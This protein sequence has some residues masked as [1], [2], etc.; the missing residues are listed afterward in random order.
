MAKS[1][2][3]VDNSVEIGSMER[4]IDFK[5]RKFKFSSKQKELLEICLNPD[6]KAVF[7]AGPA[8][9]SKA[10]PLSEPI[11]TPNGWVNMGDIKKGDLV[12]TPHGTPTEVEGVFPQGNKE[13]FKIEFN[14]GSFTHCCDDH[15][16]LTQTNAERYNRKK[17]KGGRI[18]NEK[19]GQV[20]SLKEIRESLYVSG[21]TRLNHYI[22]ITQPVQFEP[23]Q[24]LIHPYLL[25][26]LI[27]DGG[28]T[29]GTR[30]TTADKEIVESFEKLL[31]NN[32]SIHPYKDQY[33]FSIVGENQKNLCWDEIKEMGLNTKSHLKFIPENYLIDSIENRIS[34][35]QG[36]MDTDGHTDSKQG[37]AIYTT[38]SQRLAFDVKELIES[39]GGVA[40]ITSFSP[41]FTHLGEKKIGKIA[42]R[43]NV[44]LPAHIIPFSLKRKVEKYKPLTK[45]FPA[46][47]VRSIELIGEEECQCIMVKDDSHLY[48]TKDYIVTHNTYMA[49]YA[50][51]NLLA[52]NKDLEMTYIRS[53]AESAD[54]GIGSLPG[55]VNEKFLPFSIPLDDKLDEIITATSS[56]NMKKDQVIGIMPINFVRG[57]SWTSRVVVADES[58][59]FSHKELV[60][61][62]TR[63]G[64]NAKLFVCGDLMQSDIR[65]SG[66]EEMI[67]LFD[68]EDS[69]SKGI[70]VF[71]FGNEDIYRSEILRFIVAKLESLPKRRCK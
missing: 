45:Y 50:A 55:D 60:T 68:D 34:L 24:H 26:A 31:P 13:V 22:P 40:R 12:M 62:I 39:L 37:R 17:V 47:A 70:H 16:W 38:T 46:R 15:L 56:I 1:K 63:I 23:K 9:S 7:I 5:Q 59:N 18:K 2:K 30:F 43:V 32:H 51:I 6:T 69:K 53:I 44:S 36:L 25:G 33:A 27:G 58:Q 49:I 71:K 54:K 65:M 52:S 10:Q 66:F 29:M 19:I 35:L 48:L 20:R 64:E 4:K 14:D 57:S 11:L 67:D 42:Y 21:S 8:G 41:K 28:L 3:S 61:L